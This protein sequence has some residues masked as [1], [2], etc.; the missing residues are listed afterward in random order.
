[1]AVDN[2][3]ASPSRNSSKPPSNP[4]RM[5]PIASNDKSPVRPSRRAKQRR[6]VAFPIP[7]ALDYR[8]QAGIVKQMLSSRLGV[9]PL[10]CRSLSAAINV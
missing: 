2:S 10:A 6:D 3:N 7:L 1:M 5:S 9:R 8:S 4:R